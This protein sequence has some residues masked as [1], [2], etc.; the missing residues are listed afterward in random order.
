MNLADI[1][2][3]NAQRVASGLTWKKKRALPLS[4][5]ARASQFSQFEQLVLPLEAFHTYGFVLNLSSHSHKRFG[6]CPLSG[7]S[8]ELS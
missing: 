3:G 1:F 7:L 8:Y 6:A 4:R 5:S 2:L